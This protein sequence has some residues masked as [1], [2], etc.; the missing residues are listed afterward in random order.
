MFL[1][2]LVILI[3]GIFFLKIKL[4][5]PSKK[6]LETPFERIKDLVDL[7]KK[8][9][10][11]RLAMKGFM[12]VPI[13][14]GFMMLISVIKPNIKAFY[15][16]HIKTNNN[17]I[18]IVENLNVSESFNLQMI[19]FNINNMSFSTI[20]DDRFN[21]K[22]GFSNR[23]SLSISYTITSNKEVDMFTKIIKLNN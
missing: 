8:Q 11:D 18:G 14:I 19:S 3:F 22:L 23:D 4:A 6:E 20:K 5:Y 9:D 16:S 1:F 13:F 7:K 10:E 15:Y 21:Q 17:T 2:A 12:A